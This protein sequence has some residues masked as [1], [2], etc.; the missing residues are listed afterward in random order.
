MARHFDTNWPRVVKIMKVYKICHEVSAVKYNASSTTIIISV[1]WC[2][3]CP[4]RARCTDMDISH[5]YYL[6]HDV[7]S[8]L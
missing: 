5:G 6:F 1:N 8:G 4:A 2:S 7:Y 3:K